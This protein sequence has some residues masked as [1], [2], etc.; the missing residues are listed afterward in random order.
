MGPPERQRLRHRAS[1]APKAAAL[2]LRSANGG[3]RQKNAEL[4]LG[5]PRGAMSLPWSDNPA[6]GQRQA[7]PGAPL[8]LYRTVVPQAGMSQVRAGISAAATSSTNFRPAGAP[9]PH[10]RAGISAAS[11]SS[12]N[13]RPAGAPVP[14]GRAGI[15]AAATSS[16]NFRP[17]GVPV[18]HGQ[19]GSPCH[20]VL[21]LHRAFTSSAPATPALGQSIVALSSPAGATGRSPGPATRYAW[22]S[23]GIPPT[24]PSSPGGAEE[25]PFVHPSAASIRQIAAGSPGLGEPSGPDGVSSGVASRGADANPREQL[26]NAE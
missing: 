23:P 4:A 19:A 20:N 25:A 21:F 11:T 9:V 22:R 8:A 6:N 3:R 16:T 10:G 12:T 18:P 7:T 24:P 5:A 13:S 15:S 17:A 1:G 2:S 26:L 14:H